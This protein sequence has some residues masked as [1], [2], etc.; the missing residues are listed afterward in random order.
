MERAFKQE[1]W[2]EKNWDRY[3]RKQRGREP[4]RE[5]DEQVEIAHR[6]VTIPVTLEG[7]RQQVPGTPNRSPQRDLYTP[8]TA[9]QLSE[10]REMR[11][12]PTF[13]PAD[14][15]VTRRELGATRSHPPVTRLQSR[16]HA[17]EGIEEHLGA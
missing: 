14:T 12:D 11:R 4:E 10:Y 2:K 3:N 7:N 1:I 15:P 8:P 17:L 5:E 13:V 16:L 6:P 9:P